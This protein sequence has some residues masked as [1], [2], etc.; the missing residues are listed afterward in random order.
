MGVDTFF[1]LRLRLESLIHT[2]TNPLPFCEAEKIMQRPNKMS[3]AWS[4]QASFLMGRRRDLGNTDLAR[5][6]GVCVAS[7]SLVR[8]ESV[9]RVTA[10]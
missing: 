1:Y 5:S 9:E 3:K 10:A 6:D 8:A 4:K 7:W 2:L